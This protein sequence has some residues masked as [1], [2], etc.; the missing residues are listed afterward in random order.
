MEYFDAWNS[1]TEKQLKVKVWTAVK[2]LKEALKMT[3]F[4]IKPNYT[5]PLMATIDSDYQG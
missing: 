3:A 2:I 5:N 1:N 4:I